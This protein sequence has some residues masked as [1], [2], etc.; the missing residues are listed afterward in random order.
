MLTFSGLPKDTLKK[1]CSI[2][3]VDDHVTTCAG[4][5]SILNHSTSLNSFVDYQFEVAYSLLEAKGKIDKAVI[6]QSMF[7]LVFLD[8][9]MPSEPEKHL[10]SGEDL[11]KVIKTLSPKTKILVLTSIIDPFRVSSILQ[12]ID[13]SGFMLKGEITKETLPVCLEKL[14]SEGVFYS[15][16]V[17]RIIRD[18]F[19]SNTVLTFEDK[20]FL[21]L[22]SIGIPYDKISN[23]LPWSEAKVNRKEKQ[24][25]KILSVNEKNTLA[26]VHKAKKLGIV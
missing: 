25:M 2:L 19:I 10:F 14:K 1:P 18:H 17:T 22:L 26:L 4:Y 24:L 9:R 6:T 23:H 13:P 3:I 15:K 20:K 12:S 16:K 7:D 8:I 5:I 21:H 11:G